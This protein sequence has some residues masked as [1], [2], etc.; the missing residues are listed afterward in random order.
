MRR[1]CSTAP[2]PVGRRSGTARAPLPRGHVLHA[3][4]VQRHTFGGLPG[5]AAMWEQSFDWVRQALAP[6]IPDKDMAKFSAKAREAKAGM[7]L[8]TKAQRGAAGGGDQLQV[9]LV[10]STP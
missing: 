10:W 6:R 8:G 1:G 9:L 2:A 4:D 3:E 7:C 5:L